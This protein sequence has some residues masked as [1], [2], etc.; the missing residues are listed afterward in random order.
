M[1]LEVDTHLDACNWISKDDW[2][3]VVMK[4]IILYH[5]MQ[6]VPGILIFVQTDIMSPF[7][8]PTQIKTTTTDSVCF[9]TS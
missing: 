2:E 6:V 5:N 3:G 7:A 8:T 9:T 1:T 4:Q